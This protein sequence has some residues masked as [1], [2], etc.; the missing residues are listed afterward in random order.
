MPFFDRLVANPLGA[1]G[2][3]A[4]A[5]LLEAWGDSFFQTGFYRASGVGRVLALLA[6]AGVLACYG[7]VVNVPRWEFGKLIG[8]YVALFFLTAQLIAKVR[9]G[10]SPTVPIYVGGALILAG[11]LVISF[12]TA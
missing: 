12:W 5:A 4:V 9:F 8:G 2:V 11:G 1:L 3:L 6:G 10:Q 7:S